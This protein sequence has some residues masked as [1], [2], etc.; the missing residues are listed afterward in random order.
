MPWWII[1]VLSK[2]GL[3]SNI[4][5]LVLS[6]HGIYP[7]DSL[8]W[9]VLLVSPSLG[10]VH[11]FCYSH[12]LRSCWSACLC[13]ACMAIGVE[14]GME[15]GSTFP[16][17]RLLLYLHLCLIPISLSVLPFFSLLHFHLCWSVSSFECSFWWDVMW[18]YHWETKRQ[19]KD[20]FCYLCGNWIRD[21]RWLVTDRL[22]KKWHDWSLIMMYICYTPG[23]L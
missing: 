12:L 20:T 13:Q 16:G 5:V 1:T 23:D 10:H 14:S 6:M 19:Y 8:M 11:L 22:W 9:I 4:L 15:A 18:I 3:S 17:Q 21:A 2:F 7:R